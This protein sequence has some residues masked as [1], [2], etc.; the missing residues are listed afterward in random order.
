MI[1][2][3]YL[4]LLLEES[5]CVFSITWRN[6][7]V[8]RSSPLLRFGYDI[9]E[10]ACLKISRSCV[11]D[12]KST[13][14]LSKLFILPVN[15]VPCIRYIVTVVRSRR[16]VFRKASC[17]FWGVGLT[18]IFD[19]HRAALIF[20]RVMRVQYEKRCDKRQD[21]FGFW[22]LDFGVRFL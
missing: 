9:V 17:M 19:S 21:E 2:K 10:I 14:N 7:P 6:S 4:S 8:T 18:S 20:F 16:A 3:P 1:K 11:P 13:E 15:F 5:D 12:S 22:I